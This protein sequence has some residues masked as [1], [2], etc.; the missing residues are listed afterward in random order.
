MINKSSNGAL[1]IFASL[2][3]ATVLAGS[4]A[5]EAREAVA[6]IQTKLIYSGS[7]YEYYG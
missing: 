4:S 5:L 7:S 3:A 2:T 6:H 1:D